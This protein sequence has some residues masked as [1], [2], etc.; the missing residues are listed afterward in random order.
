[1]QLRAK[2]SMELEAYQIE[3]YLAVQLG[4]IATVE[5]V[6]DI[7][8]PNEAGWFYGSIN[9]KCGWL[10]VHAFMRIPPPPPGSP[11]APSVIAVAHNSEGTK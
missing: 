5:H 4:D 2:A 7:N 8:N 6:G 11:P 1:M 10:R 9:G 3:G